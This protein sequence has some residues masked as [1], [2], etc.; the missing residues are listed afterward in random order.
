MKFVVEAVPAYEKGVATKRPGHI[1]WCEG[2]KLRGKKKKL[3]SRNEHC[4]TRDVHSSGM[5]CGVV[6]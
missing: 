1:M 4:R 2:R 6:R 5:L 3:V